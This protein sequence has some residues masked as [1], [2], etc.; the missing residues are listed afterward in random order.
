LEGVAVQ[1]PDRVIPY[2]KTEAGAA[3]IAPLSVSP[4]GFAAGPN[5]AAKSAGGIGLF[6]QGK[7]IFEGELHV[8]DASGNFI[9]TIKVQDRA[10]GGQSRRQ[11]G[12]WDLK[13][14]KG[15]AVSEGTYLVK[16]GVKTADGKKVRVSILLGIR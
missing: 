7:R 13:D 11:V 14:A 5:P 15:R 9:N 16:G 10:N 12:S 4:D 2:V 6:R 1:A 3:V 8:Y